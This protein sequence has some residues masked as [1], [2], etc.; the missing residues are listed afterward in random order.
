MTEDPAA[1]ARRLAAQAQIIQ[2]FFLDGML[3]SVLPTPEDSASGGSS[4]A[5]ADSERNPNLL[6]PI[7]GDLGP[8]VPQS[9]TEFPH[10]VWAFH[11]SEFGD[12]ARASGGYSHKQ[13]YELSGGIV[14]DAVVE[15][16]SDGL[17][18]EWTSYGSTSGRLGAVFADIETGEHLARC[19]LGSLETGTWHMKA[20]QNID[21]MRPWRLEFFVIRE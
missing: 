15:W 13:R 20:G 5:E 14:L 4:G 21:L 12:A 17:H 16:T 3:H 8:A 19:D 9:A 10:A 18:L 6:A 2:Q 7:W 11:W 1:R